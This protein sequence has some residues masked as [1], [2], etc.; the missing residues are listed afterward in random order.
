VWKY[1]QHIGV[2]GIAEYMPVVLMM[3]F[4]VVVF[5]FIFKLLMGIV[6]TA[7]RDS[8]RGVS[9]ESFAFF[10]H[11]SLMC[12]YWFQMYWHNY[13]KGRPFVRWDLL[14]LALQCYEPDENMPEWKK[15]YLCMD[16]DT[17]ELK[18]AL[19]S[20][21]ASAHS[22]ETETERMSSWQLPMIHVL[23]FDNHEFSDKDVEFVLKAYGRRRRGVISGIV[24][25]EKKRAQSIRYHDLS[26]P[27]N[28]HAHEA[29][30]KEQ[31]KK[32]AES[33]CEQ[34]LLEITSD[35]SS[36][37]ITKRKPSR[38]EIDVAFR[39]ADVFC[40]GQVHFFFI[41]DLLEE[42]GYRMPKSN[43]YK[44][45]LDYDADGNM[46]LDREEV[47]KFIHDDAVVGRRIHKMLGEKKNTKRV[48]R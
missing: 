12:K 27:H 10:D 43:M 35:L 25:E 23:G 19:V 36:E 4:K 31:A 26:Q 22:S 14:C 20:A 2:S 24:E 9:L 1:T 5:M 6:M 46:S 8:R 47:Q 32:H 48:H 45:M 33:A 16:G 18:K 44:L 3:F 41:E 7:W 13:V 38:E 29:E 11:V 34:F 39:G 42:L 15:G 28:T 17:A 21:V 30:W 37:V 40:T